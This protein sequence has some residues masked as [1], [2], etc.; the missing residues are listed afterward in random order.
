MKVVVAGANGLVG[1][2]LVR[3]LR[4]RGDE[5]VALARSPQAA[6]EVKWDGKGQGDWSRS[7]EGAEAVVNLAGASVAGK[8]WTEAYKQEIRASRI[9]ATRALVEALRGPARKARV[10][11]SASAVG[12]Y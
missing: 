6:R 3:A 2:S 8:R 5:V 9:D 4:E 7:L 10:F 11:V 12:Y 1:T